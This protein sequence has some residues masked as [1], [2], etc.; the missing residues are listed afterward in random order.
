MTYLLQIEL[1]ELFLKFQILQIHLKVKWQKFWFNLLNYKRVKRFKNLEINLEDALRNQNLEQAILIKEIQG[2]I[3]RKV[4][5]G[6]SQYIPLTKKS[7]AKIR[8]II[9]ADFGERMKKCNLSINENLQI[10]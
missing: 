5:K 4:K 10:A 6:L 9:I 7:R 3:P 8:A 1:Q 2:L